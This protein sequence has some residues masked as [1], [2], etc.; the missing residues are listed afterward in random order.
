MRELRSPPPTRFEEFKAPL[1]HPPMHTLERR[2]LEIQIMQLQCALNRATR[3]PGSS[4]V[5][6]PYKNPPA[7]DPN[8]VAELEADGFFMSNNHF[9]L[10]PHWK[11]KRLR[12]IN[13]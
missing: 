5:L 12:Q 7:L 8:T 1:Y 3:R 4:M 2:A 9:S 13:D 11:P 6:S 10:N